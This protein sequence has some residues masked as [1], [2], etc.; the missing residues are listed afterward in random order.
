MAGLVVFGVAAGFAA[1]S[2]DPQ[3]L[4]ALRAL[5]GVG[6]ALTMPT[7]L[8]IITTSFPE[9]ERGRA[10]GLWVGIAGGGAILGLFGSGLLLEWFSWSSFFVLNV[11]LA[12]L[13]LVG[14]V[15]VVPRSTDLDPPALDVV[16]AALSLVAV[17][18]LVFGI[19]EG[20][21][22]GWTDP[23]VLGSLVGAVVA[24]VLFVLRELRKSDPMLDPRLF[25]LRGFGTGSA[26]LT[27]QFFASFGFF[28]I[29]M[30]YLQ[31]SVGLSPLMSATAMLPMPFVLIPLARRAPAIADRLG[32]RRVGAAG[33]TFMAA[34]FLV[35]SRVQVDFTYWVFAIG[36]VLFAI[37]MALAAAPATTAIVSSLPAAKQGVAS[38]VNDTAR[39]FGSALGIAVLGSVLNSAYR[40]GMQDAVAGLP[41]EVGDSALGS[42]AFLSYAP[43]D[44]MGP[45]GQALAATAKQA[46][47]DGVSSAV[48]VGAVVLLVAAAFVAWRGTGGTVSVP[49]PDEDDGVEVP[50]A[51]RS[52]GR[53]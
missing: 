7:T 38:A 47:V 52:H 24:L 15:L 10:V 1:F 13:A 18:G 28:F 14:T 9:S 22:N 43:I 40:G 8:S 53:A 27:V 37:G 2:S 25:A 33:L 51:P 4:I 45:A 31:F 35:I 32:F 19:I 34:G 48:V 17:A 5:M 3:Q 39:E 42:I 41:P 16:S 23:W 20:P 11:V 29:A 21:S 6:A 36:L 46:F 50:T 12:V 26:S 49:S 44:Q 30:Q